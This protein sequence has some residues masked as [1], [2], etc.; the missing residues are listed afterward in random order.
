[1]NQVI[2][3]GAL[4]IGLRLSRAQN[5]QLLARLLDGY[6][7]VDLAEHVP[8]STDLCIVDEGG[9]ERVSEALAGWKGAERPTYAPVLLLVESSGGRDPYQQYAGALGETVDAIHRIPSTR[10]AL[11]TRVESLLET[12]RYA[13][14][15][16]SQRRFADRV[17]ETSPVAKTVLDT[18]GS[19]VR[20]NARAEELLGLSSFEIEG[21][22]Y[23]GPEWRMT[24]PGGEPIPPGKLPFDRVMASGS[25]VNGDELVVERPDGER[26]WVTVDM[27]PVRDD[28]G[29]IEYVVAAMQDV[30]ERRRLERELR[31]S[32]EL[33]RA[34]LE[35]ITD[36]VVITDDEGAFTYV[37][38]NTHHL[39]GYDT[40][41]VHELG[42]I[43]ALLGSDP[44]RDGVGA[45]GLKENVELTVTDAE[46]GEHI[47]LVTVRSVD[48]Q[49]GT[50]LYTVRDIT[51][52]AEAEQA[53]YETQLS[54]SLALE[55]ADAA[56][57]GW[58]LEAGEAVWD[59]TLAPLLDLEPDG[60]ED[61]V[62]TFYRYAH[63][64]DLDDAVA[65]IERALTDLEPFT[66]SLR[67]APDGQPERWL[68]L[69][70][71]VLTDD[72]GRSVR[73]LGV[74]TDVTERKQRERLLRRAERAIEAS[75]HAVY[76][77][78]P[79]GT[80]TYA[81]PAFE[82]VTG[83]APAEVYGRDPSMLNSGEQDDEYF[84]ELWATLEAGKRWDEELV[85]RRKDGDR[86]HAAQ[87][88]APITDATGTIEGFVAIQTDITD[89]KDRLQ[90]LQVM[91]RVLRHNL[92]N[93]MNV[94]MGRADL[95]RDAAT[96][97]VA[98]DATTILEQSE[99]L[100]DMTDKQRRITRV[101]SAEPSPTTVDDV[102]ML[103]HI[104][105]AARRAHPEAALTV[106][107][108][109]RA[110]ATVTD[111]I[112]LAVEELVDNAMVH[113]DR[114]PP[115]VAVTV[116]ATADTVTVRVADAGPGIP[117]IERRIVTGEQEIAPLYHG[118]GL[119]LW[120][121]WWT[122][123]R[124]RGSLAFQGN[125]P[126]GS[127]VTVSLPRASGPAADAG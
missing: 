69:R 97:Q 118:S 7:L 75:G 38:P 81:N 60:A 79:D 87:T 40:D 106:D 42:H 50:R 66:A 85:N 33:H 18:D 25:P 100:L 113:H 14:E 105:D 54:R 101:L 63:P 11:R 27:A 92:H 104:E 117:E 16:A 53:L 120:L 20:A 77:T 59:D 37:C 3:R 90:Q 82:Q 65:A 110:F 6:E 48:I 112:E 22:D 71:Q 123:Q 91:D 76:I 44:A 10:S 17:F 125:E 4:T 15:L 99:E 86:Y 95:I 9:H 126:R 67:F 57:W 64:D 115:E 28:T 94:I 51:E 52:R 41:G 88:I 1:M 23:D 89:H 102:D 119:G 68:D 13:R 122:V 32:E 107:L 34:T 24:D 70:G 80:I 109:D 49:G 96:G 72:A 61:L 121:V 19:I 62:D 45:T 84:D 30:S 36:T 83:Y 35:N 31:A 21:R 29:D 5:Q 55:A 124:S 116:L 58:D 98:D 74:V 12:R 46:G 56:V 108:P 47:V 8:G 93:V 127:V 26:V 78:E 111:G 114:D 73:L 39:F 43:E 2:Q 103:G